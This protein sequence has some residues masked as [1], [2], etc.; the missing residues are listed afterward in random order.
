M[1]S[2]VLVAVVLH[3]QTVCIKPVASQ[4]YPIDVVISQTEINVENQWCERVDRT[5]C[6]MMTKLVVYQY[7]AT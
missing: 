6:K 7:S 2:S 5:T 4:D 3:V 1:D